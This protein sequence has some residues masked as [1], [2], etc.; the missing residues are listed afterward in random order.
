MTNKVAT[1]TCL[2]CLLCEEQC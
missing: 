1:V 2:P